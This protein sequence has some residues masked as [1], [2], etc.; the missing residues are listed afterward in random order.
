M[1]GENRRWKRTNGHP[2]WQHWNVSLW[3]GNDEGL[4][5][6]AVELI[7]EH[8]HAGATT[9]MLDLLPDETPDGAR[10]DYDT[11]YAAL[12]GLVEDADA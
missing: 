3:I 10:Y 9:A 6:L 4:Y 12:D 7:H 5:R 2:S 11:V 1:L 8:G